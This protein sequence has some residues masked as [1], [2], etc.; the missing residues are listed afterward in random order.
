MLHQGLA[1]LPATVMYR[2]HQQ[3]NPAGFLEESQHALLLGV[4]EEG[5]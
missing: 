5:T 3:G 2:V 4:S 1:V